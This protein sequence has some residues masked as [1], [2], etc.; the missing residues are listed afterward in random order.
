M[1]LFRD[2][3]VRLT[4]AEWT[5]IAAGMGAEMASLRETES[6]KQEVM[7]KFK[8]RIQ[9]HTNKLQDLG[10]KVTS[11]EETRA[12]ECEERGDVKRFVMELYRLDTGEMVETRPMTATER[13]EALQVALPGV[14]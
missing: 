4:D 1:K 7:T 8:E 11:H 10:G 5:A 3:K 2:L 9:V 14:N 12:V 6:E 13:Q